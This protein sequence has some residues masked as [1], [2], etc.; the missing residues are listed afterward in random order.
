MNTYIIEMHTADNLKIVFV[1]A[2]TRTKAVKY[3]KA[4]FTQPLISPVKAR[5]VPDA[6]VNDMLK[7]GEYDMTDARIEAPLVATVVN[8]KRLGALVGL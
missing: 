1:K 5:M 4:V 2:E 7:A 3:G 8:R 6:T